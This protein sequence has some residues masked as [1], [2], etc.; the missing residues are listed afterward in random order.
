MTDVKTEIG[1]NKEHV[2]DTDFLTSSNIPVK[3]ELDFQIYADSATSQVEKDSTIKSS[4]NT[5]PCS[6]M[7]SQ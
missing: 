4:T 2:F 7:V 6:F 1:N 3:S 5:V